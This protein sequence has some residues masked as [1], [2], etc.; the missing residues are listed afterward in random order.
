MTNMEGIFA[1]RIGGE[2]PRF[3]RCDA[4][5][6]WGWG[7]YFPP[8]SGSGEFSCWTFVALPHSMYMRSRISLF[9]I[10]FFGQIRSC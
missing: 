8:G 4:V 9:V 7:L 2:S 5:A 10:K 1:C 6:D 3:D